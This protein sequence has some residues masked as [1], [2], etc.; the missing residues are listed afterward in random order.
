[1]WFKLAINPDSQKTP[2]TISAFVTEHEDTSEFLLFVAKVFGGAKS[3]ITEQLQT[4]AVP[5]KA[6]AA[7]EKEK[8]A[9]EAAA[10]AYDKKFAEALAKLSDCAKG[11]DQQ[12]ELAANARVVM[13]D[14]NQAARAISKKEFTDN[15]INSIKL[16]GAPEGIKNACSAARDKLKS[17]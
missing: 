13:R 1:E 7:E 10:S 5:G 9:K 17:L 16:T 3:T 12:Q 11:G 6:A 8:A 14:F 2:L 4:V 15:D